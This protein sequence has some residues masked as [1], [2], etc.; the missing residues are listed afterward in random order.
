MSSEISVHQVLVTASPGDAI[1]NMARSLRRV[2]RQL[3]PSE[4]YAWRIDPT[5]Y[6][7]VRP[8]VEYRGGR[9]DSLLVFHAAIGEPPVHDFLLTRDEP[10][11]LWY[12]N[13]TPPE[14]FAPYDPHFAGLLELGRDEIDL[15]RPRVARAVAD[16]AYN[17]RELEAM[18]Y[19]D[20][21]VVPPVR[22]LSRLSARAPHPA[23]AREL[24]TLESPIILC[25]AQ[26]MPHK[27]PDFLVEMMYI[28]QTYQGMRGSL[29][30]VGHQRLRQYANAVRQQVAELNLPRVYLLGAVSEGDLCA[31]Y[32]A[33]T[34]VVS[35]SEHEGF[36]LPLVEAMTFEKPIIARG[37]AAI[38]ETVG[39]AGLLLAP[40]HGPTMFAEA[41]AELLANNALREYLV[42][43]GKERVAELQ[44]AR[45]DDAILDLVR[46][47]A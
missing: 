29:L 23:A 12:H 5:L 20:V 22:D 25:V 37:C 31:I 7:E 1:T 9:R 34:V 10:L 27:R 43:R 2:F 47:A 38:P 40:Q 18:G 32:R 33:A 6:G 19:R 35:A 24:E 21:L 14:Y 44:S 28:A 11:V 13:V 4:I 15:L 41:T 39:D 16:S 30:F 36:C 45:S 46:S 42:R 17:A 26:L 8:L 3:G